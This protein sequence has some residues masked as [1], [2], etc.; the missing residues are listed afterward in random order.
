MQ[1][2]MRNGTIR[3]ETAWVAVLLAVAFSLPLTAQVTIQDSGDIFGK[4][5]D[6]GVWE[7]PEPRWHQPVNLKGHEGHLYGMRRFQADTGETTYGFIYHFCTDPSHKGTRLKPFSLSLGMDEPL[8]QNWSHLGFLDVLLDGES[9]GDTMA[10]FTTT[11]SGKEKT[12]IIMALENGKA[13]VKIIFSPESQNVRLPA[14][15]Y[16]APKRELKSIQVCLRCYPNE[17]AAPCDLGQSVRNRH[18]A[19]AK[20]DEGVLGTEPLKT[21]KLGS[22]EPWIVYY[23]ANLDKGVTRTLSDGKSQRTGY[24][25]CAFA[26]IPA[27]TREVTVYLGGYN[28]D[29]FISYPPTAREIHFLFWDFGCGKGEK[30]N[31]QTLDYFK[32]LKIE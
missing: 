30:N 22:D 23:D 8:Q 29:T 6:D 26:Y 1:A 16:I 28:I 31:K 20:R 14:A 11:G 7:Q 4:V 10:T 17:Y 3:K 18:I 9:L 19:T 2:K 13:A 32:S 5:K 21:I 25:P 24:G 27:E 15:I 12:E